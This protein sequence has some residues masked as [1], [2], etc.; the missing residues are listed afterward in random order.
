MN[1]KRRL[2]RE[3]ALW[4]LFALDQAKPSEQFSFAERLHSHLCESDEL[5]L[6][7]FPQL[8][9]R[10]DKGARLWS[11]GSTWER[12]KILR[13]GVCDHLGLLDALIGRCSLHWKLNRMNAVDRNILR[14]AAYELAFLEDTPGRAVL[15]E[16]IEI[17]KR[18]GTED[19]GRFVNGILDRIAHELGRV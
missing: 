5:V 11:N 16:A 13:A 18:Y 7:F 12:I 17:A 15:N 3:A 10:R 14:I 1:E 19:S 9:G 2:I 8:R 4:Q 6:L